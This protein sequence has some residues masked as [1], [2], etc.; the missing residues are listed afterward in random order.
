M[1]GVSVNA[2]GEG[3]RPHPPAPD[4]LPERLR[5]ALAED[6]AFLVR[7]HDR[8]PDGALLAALRAAP[9]ERWFALRLEG[10]DFEE[11]RRLMTLAL[12]AIEDPDDTAVLDE[13]AA[14][15]A[16][17]YLTYNYQAAPTESVWVDPDSLER[18]EAMF[19]VREWYR[20]F[21]VKV[22]DWRVRSDDH[23]VHELQLVELALR[24]TARPAALRMVADFMRDHPLAWIP[25][26][27]A[28]IVARSRSPF[29][30]GS[31]LITVA[32]LRALGALLGS[33]LGVD[34][35]PVPIDPTRSARRAEKT[36]GDAPAA[37][38]PG[39][40]AGW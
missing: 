38:L 14:E 32:Y 7:L 24:D 36:C 30:A 8:E 11:G 19:Q 12:A 31:A 37:Y 17:I 6:V 22:P 27:S 23:L 18:Q 26:F 9:V 28:R 1:T 25:Q 35:T 33:V 15:F 4:D 16:A 21:A 40:S 34:M 29:F 3:P 13:L 20:R 39:Q 5:L 2:A 10:Q